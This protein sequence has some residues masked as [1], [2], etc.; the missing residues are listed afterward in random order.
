MRSSPLVLIVAR[1][2]GQAPEPSALILLK[3][4]ERELRL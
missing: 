3:Q 2:E 4:R 1:R